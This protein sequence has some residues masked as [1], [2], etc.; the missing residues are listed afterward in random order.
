MSAILI[1]HT[2]REDTM[3]DE[4][5]VKVTYSLPQGLVD[6]VREA[7]GGGAAPSYSAFVERAM[8]E[9]LRRTRE[10]QLEQAFAE[11]AE[12]PLLAADIE[13]ATADFETLDS[14]AEE[15]GG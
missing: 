7:V 3:P 10:R 8:R 13:A 12:D 2:P 4:R 11:A 14:E 1:Y 15:N 6:R 9:E 5:S